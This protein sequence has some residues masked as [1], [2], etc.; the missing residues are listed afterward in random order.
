MLIGGTLV[1]PDCEQVYLKFAK[2]KLLGF[3][4]TFNSIADG[5]TGGSLFP[6]A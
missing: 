6:I 5:G 1:C 2:K 3:R 4:L